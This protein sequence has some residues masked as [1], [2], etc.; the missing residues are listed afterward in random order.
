MKYSKQIISHTLPISANTI[1][2]EYCTRFTK[3][4]ANAISDSA[5]M[6]GQFKENIPPIIAFCDG[7]KTGVSS[8]DI[9]L[10]IVDKFKPTAWTS[11]SS[12]NIN[13]TSEELYV[14]FM[15]MHFEKYD[16]ESID[17]VVMRTSLNNGILYDNA[18]IRELMCMP[19][20]PDYK[21]MDIKLQNYLLYIILMM[22]NNH[23]WQHKP[24]CF[25]IGSR[26]KSNKNICRY[27]F[28][29]ERHCKTEF[30]NN[31]IVFERQIGKIICILYIY[32]L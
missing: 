3:W 8:K 20:G 26:N 29:K 14:N 31:Q 18:N 6:A 27:N 2:C 21:N 9:N 22:V 1:N 24:S 10:R 11:I 30:L 32:S 23:A 17:N 25:K 4:E 5:K 13:D 15:K 28:P 12:N 19:K 7:C 16:F